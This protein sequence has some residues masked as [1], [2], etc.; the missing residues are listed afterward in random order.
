MFTLKCWLWQTGGFHVIRDFTFLL[1]EFS[2]SL[3]IPP[4]GWGAWLFLLGYFHIWRSSLHTGVQVEGE[5]GAEGDGES[6]GLP[7]TG[8]R[9]AKFQAL[10]Q[11]S[12]VTSTHKRS[13]HLHRL[14][15]HLWSV[16]ADHNVGGISSHFIWMLRSK[17]Q[18]Q[19]Y[20]TRGLQTKS[21]ELGC[22]WNK[23]F[24]N[25]I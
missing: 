3:N 9:L 2:L 15:W 20:V 14:E 8:Q 13:R 5:G 4:Q 21:E 19:P 10:G 6:D 22:I 23:L 17:F 12:R 7:H 1:Q 16:L 25:Y 18:T 24:W 11:Q